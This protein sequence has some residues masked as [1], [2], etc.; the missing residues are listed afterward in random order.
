LQEVLDFDAY[1]FDLDGTV[2]LGDQLLPGVPEAFTLLR[3]HGKIIRFLT[4][5]TVRTRSECS[6]R[7]RRMGLEAWDE[8]VVTAAYAASVYMAEQEQTAVVLAIG[9]PAMKAEL[10]ECGVRMTGDWREATHVLVGMDMQF[11]YAKLSAA[12]RAVRRGAVL[13]AA[14]P[15]PNCP[16]EQDVL[17]DTWALVRAIET[18]SGRE[19]AAVIGKPSFYF[20]SKVLE[21]TGLRPENCLMVGDRLE[22][23][24]RFG[25]HFGM[26]TALVLTGSSTLEELAHFPKRPD[27]VWD[28]LRELNRLGVKTLTNN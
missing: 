11:D 24:I 10:M 19:A 2:L 12:V 16:V 13:I 5:T 26:G 25:M 15:D 23:D 18:A 27:Y 21:W 3:G 7:L 8:E 17:P 22:T 1:F 20:G 28:S 14:N 4:N 6:A 9:E